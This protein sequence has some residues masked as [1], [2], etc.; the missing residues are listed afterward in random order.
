MRNRPLMYIAG[1][2]FSLA[3][4][5]FNARLKELLS[6]RFN[7]YLPQ[8][9][10]GLLTEMIA[11]GMDSEEASRRVFERD[12]LAIRKCEFFL[13]ILDGRVIDEGAAFELGVAYSIGKRCFGLQTDPRRLLPCGNNPMIAQALEHI[14]QSIEEMKEWLLSSPPQPA[15]NADPA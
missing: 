8:Q 5:E 13:M 3:E 11:A 12:V 1:P 6:L 10:G 2:L 4:R 15:T 9:D 14:F 7:I